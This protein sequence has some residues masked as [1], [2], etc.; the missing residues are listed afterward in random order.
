[1]DELLDE[2]DG[3][4]GFARARDVLEYEVDDERRQP[5]RHLVGD[6]DLRRHR[7]RAGERKHLL[8][9]TRQGAG[10]LGAA[11]GQAGEELVGVV[12]GRPPLVRGPDAPHGHAQVLLHRQAGEDAPPLRDVHETGPAD[13]VGRRLG[14]VAAVE[15]DPPAERRDQ[16]GYGP[17]E[18]ALP[19]SVGPEDGDDRPGGN[20]DGDLE[21]RLH[22]A[23]PHVESL[24]RQERAARGRVRGTGVDVRFGL[25]HLARASVELT[26]ASP[27]SA[28][29]AGPLGPRFA[30]RRDT[31]LA[32][33]SLMLPR[34]RRFAPGR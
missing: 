33:A 24:G 5:E 26:H 6:D 9:T 10:P 27:L 2:H 34:S 18:R 30:T 1:M 11:L 16:P 14:D 28:L 31:R 8:L 7:E 25:C 22:R 13:V 3:D 19:G 20:V 15:H 23:V 12:D 4:A 32:F 29:R 21:Q 17:G